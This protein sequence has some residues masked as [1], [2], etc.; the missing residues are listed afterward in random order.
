MSASSQVKKL[1]E[2]LVSRIYDLVVE[3]VLTETASHLSGVGRTKP[4]TVEKTPTPRKSVKPSRRF[5]RLSKVGCKSIESTI[6]DCVNS[7][8]G[9][10]FGEVFAHVS[11]RFNY[12]Y[13][14]AQGRIRKLVEEGRLTRRL[15]G[16]RRARYFV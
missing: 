5:A 7:N 3:D 1:A 10:T 13:V 16:P 15:D 11:G 9:S 14:A 12:G 4:P 8:P 6:F 2:E